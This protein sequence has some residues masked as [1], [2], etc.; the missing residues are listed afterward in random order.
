MNFIK[1]D[2]ETYNVWVVVCYQVCRVVETGCKNEAN[3]SS[4]ISNV[5]NATT[6]F[7]LIEKRSYYIA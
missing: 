4:A 5:Y 1:F 6:A 3:L 7:K 2:S